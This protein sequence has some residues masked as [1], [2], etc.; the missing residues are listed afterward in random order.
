[1]DG[2]APKSKNLFLRKDIGAWALWDWGSAAFNAVI[3]TFVFTVY[4]TSSQFSSHAETYLGWA[5]GLAGL[6]IALV[7]PA[8]GQR[9]DRSGRRVFW[10][11]IHTLVVVGVSASLF[12][13]TPGQA[14]LFL[15]LALLAIG[16]IFFEL[17]SVNYNAMLNDISTPRTIGRIS[18]FG[19]GLGYLGGIVLLVIVYFA[20]IQPE[21][22]IFGITSENGLDVRVTMVI[23]AAWTLIFSL[24]VM[25]TGRDDMSKRTG[26]K[27][28]SLIDTYKEIARQIAH[29]WR[30]DRRVVWFLFASAIFRDGLAGVFTF[31]GVIAANVFGFSPGQVIQF[32]LAANVVAGIATITGGYLDDRLGPKR[33]IYLSLISMITAGFFVFIFHDGGIGKF[34]FFGLLLCV[35]VGPAQSA[36]RSYLGR[37]APK[38][39]EGE[40]F[41][42]YATTGRAVSFL[43]PTMFSLAITVGAALTGTTLAGAKHFGILGIMLVL[44]LGLLMLIPVQDITAAERGDKAGASSTSGGVGEAKENS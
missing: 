34:W 13:V 15:G 2:S 32:G 19:W 3:T 25:I 28:L 24:P 43:A 14:G 42:L 17:A 37:L 35:F 7:A 41:G 26:A 16:N 4:L 38:G 8:S 21:V 11:R 39:H 30:T 10:L 1:M 36:S 18:G 9:A 23:C 12:S 5:L 20:L 40:V 6:T 27:Q 44:L 33:V 29:L 22:G 31:G